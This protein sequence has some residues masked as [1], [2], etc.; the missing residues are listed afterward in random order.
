M[1]LSEKLLV[2]SLIINMLSSSVFL[3][4]IEKLNLLVVT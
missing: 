4:I 2:K 1:V 3:I